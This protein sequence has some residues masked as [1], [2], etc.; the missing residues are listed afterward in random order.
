MIQLG[1]LA[2]YDNTVVTLSSYAF[3]GEYLRV[4]GRRSPLVSAWLVSLLLLCF[5]SKEY[6]PLFVG[7]AVFLWECGRRNGRAALRVLLLLLV[8]GLASVLS[9]KLY[10]DLQGFP[11][12]F[13]LRVHY[14]QPAGGVFQVWREGGFSRVLLAWTIT[15]ACSLSWNSIFFGLLVIAAILWR[16]RNFLRT[17]S[18]ESLDLVVIFS[19]L[20][21][22]AAKFLRPSIATLRYEY[23]AM[24]GLL[25]LIAFFL[26]KTI[27][28]PRFG[29]IVASALLAMV[30]FFR[31]GDIVLSTLQ[32]GRGLYAFWNYA[33]WSLLAWLVL[34]LIFRTPRGAVVACAIL[35]CAA[36]LGL[37]VAQCRPYITSA[38]WLVDYGTMGPGEIVRLLQ[39]KKVADLECVLPKGVGFLV[40]MAVNQPNFRWINDLALEESFV[41]GP[42]QVK[43]LLKP[44]RYIVWRGTGLPT[45]VAQELQSLGFG[46]EAQADGYL[47]LSRLPDSAP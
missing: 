25:L 38:D 2:T 27:G 8:A 16:V 18:L 32:S 30:H 34:W 26:E 23:P 28:R 3:L 45:E 14:E 20:Y 10:C 15:M 12:D 21:I 31:F 5:W 6:A 22:L 7:A 13:L 46:L 29:W 40:S 17:G 47:L 44:V 11:A 41:R 19:C 33:I 39:Q 37:T 36:N 1:F 4:S 43:D 24:P 42:E 35:L 9:W